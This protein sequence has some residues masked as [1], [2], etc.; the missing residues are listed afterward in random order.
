VFEAT[1]ATTIS[2]TMSTNM[3]TAQTVKLF[4][5]AMTCTPEEFNEQ[6]FQ[7]RLRNRIIKCI[8]QHLFDIRRQHSDLVNVL[9]RHQATIS[10]CWRALKLPQQRELLGKVW[11]DMPTSRPDDLTTALPVEFR[12]HPGL[13]LEDLTQD[14]SVVLQFLHNRAAHCPSLYFARDLPST[15]VGEPWYQ[16]D[17]EDP[18]YAGLMN[19]WAGIK[20]PVVPGWY[21]KL[22]EYRVKFVHGVSSVDWYHKSTKPGADDIHC[23]GFVVTDAF[24]VV[25]AQSRVYSSLARICRELMQNTAMPCGQWQDDAIYPR[26]PLSAPISKSDALNRLRIEYGPP[27]IDLARLRS[28]IET[29]LAKASDT[30]FSIRQDPGFFE[31]AVQESLRGPDTEEEGE[32][33]PEQAR[34]SAITETVTAAILDVDRWAG[35]GDTLLG[36]ERAVNGL[37]TDPP[38]SNKDIWDAVGLSLSAFRTCVFALCE[39]LFVSLEEMASANAPFEGFFALDSGKKLRGKAQ[40][41][42]QKIYNQLCLFLNPYSESALSKDL[43]LSILMDRLRREIGITT[44]AQQFRE[45]RPRARRLLEGLCFVAEWQRQ[46]TAYQPWFEMVKSDLTDAL[47]S[48]DTK[49]LRDYIVQWRRGSWSSGWNLASTPEIWK[50]LT[51]FPREGSLEYPLLD[52]P[53]WAAV[54][55]RRRAEGVLDDFWVELTCLANDRSL[56]S[57]RVSVL[58]Q[59]PLQRTPAWTGPEPSVKRETETELNEQLGEVLQEVPT[60][61]EAPPSAEAPTERPAEIPAAEPEPTCLWDTT[62]AAR[63]ERLARRQREELRQ[64]QPP[65]M[66]NPPLST[67]PQD[68]SSLN[69]KIL[70]THKTYQVFRM[71]WHDKDSDRR[72]GTLSWDDFVSAMISIGFRQYSRSGSRHGF[73][74]DPVRLGTNQRIVIHQTHGSGDQSKIKWTKARGIGKNLTELYGWTLE[75]FAIEPR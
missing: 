61:P 64:N 43:G 69:G 44:I 24:K 25:E 21:D 15:S 19:V 28:L 22:Q 67:A 1:I 23:E 4:H 49:L 35:L 39:Y 16:S 40:A 63:Q 55:A 18:V 3:N 37:R 14:P 66:T 62:E 50:D 72:K 6:V 46:A 32:Y 12:M 26:K 65:P 70:V 74:P 10:H 36:L 51:R 52:E 5:L 38:M 59:R 2:T 33:D 71:L 53:T 68:S 31:A 47:E 17:L 57:D 56:L 54:L 13:N 29:E 27:T 60:P 11:P 73:E 30:L 41:R 58:L 20:E 48:E 7:D 9:S 75:T 45:F 34:K 8:E 42:L